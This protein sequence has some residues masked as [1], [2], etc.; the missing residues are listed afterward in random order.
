MYDAR[1]VVLAE[2]SNALRASTHALRMLMGLGSPVEI[3]EESCVN[4]VRNCFEEMYR[5]IWSFPAWG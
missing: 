5:G 3:P 1:T 2:L 4:R